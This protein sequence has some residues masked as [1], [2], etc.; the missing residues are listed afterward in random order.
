MSSISAMLLQ[1][2]IDGASVSPEDNLAVCVWSWPSVQHLR[3]AI[4]G[5]SALLSLLLMNSASLAAPT[6]RATSGEFL[7]NSETFAGQERPAVARKRTGEFMVAFEHEPI[8]KP[9]DVNARVF[10]ADGSPL[11][12]Q[13]IVNKIQEGRHEVVPAVGID[14]AGN[15]VVAWQSFGAQ[16][17]GAGSLGVFFRRFSPLGVAL[18]DDIRANSA[19]VMAGPGSDCENNPHFCADVAPTLAV[20]PT[21]GFVIAWSTYVD[22]ANSW[23]VYARRFDAQGNALGPEFRVHTH[24]TNEQRFPA[25]AINAAGEILVAWQS[26]DQD[27]SGCGIFARRFD[28]AN[29]PLGPEFQV[30]AYSIGTQELPGIAMNS[31]GDAVVIWRGAGAG[32]ASGAFARLYSPQGIPRTGDLQ[33]S[34]NPVELEGTRMDVAMDEHGNFVIAWEA[35]HSGTSGIKMRAFGADGT[36]APFE[37]RVNTAPDTHQTMPTV[38]L[39]EQRRLVVAW[40]N[41]GQDGSEWGVYGRLFSLEPDNTPPNPPPHPIVATSYTIT[42]LGLL[43]FQSGF[44]S[45]IN[46][47]GQVV[48]GLDSGTLIEGGSATGTT[49]FVWQAG[50]YTLLP[51]LEGN[52]G[53]PTRGTSALAINDAG[54]IT[55]RS[56]DAAGGKAVV[57]NGG[58][59]TDLGGPHPSHREDVGFD[60]NNAGAI[61]GRAIVPDEYPRPVRWPTGPG[62]L[63]TLGVF[64]GAQ[65]NANAINDSG[66]I[67][68]SFTSG[69]AGESRAFLW[70]NGVESILST[71]GGAF[72]NAAYGIN[73]YGVIVGKSET[74]NGETRAIRWMAGQIEELGTLGGS[75]FS[76]ALA[77][78][79]AGSIVGFFRT[80]SGGFGAFIWQNNVMRDLNALISNLDGWESL[81]PSAINES[82]WIVGTGKR[83]GVSHP[84]LLIPAV[85]RAPVAGDDT[86]TAPEDTPLKIPL[87]TLLANDT[88]PD[89]SALSVTAV[90]NPQNGTVSLTGNEITFTPNLNFNGTASFEY[91]VSDGTFA[92]VGLVTVNVNSVN[93]SPIS[94][95]NNYAVDED[96]LLVGT[97]V[98]GNDKDDHGGAPGENNLP[99]SAE[100]VRPPAYARSFAFRADGTFDYTPELNYDR[101]DS[102]SYRAK[103]ALGALSG[104][105]EVL[106]NVRPINDS[107][108]WNVVILDQPGTYGVLFSFTLPPD[109]FTDPDMGQSIF[110]EASGLPSGIAFDP[111]TRTFSGVPR[112]AGR[113][114]IRVCGTDNGAPPL[115]GEGSFNVVI[116]KAILT[117]SATGVDKVYDGT[118]SA[119]VTLNDNRIS[120]DVFTTSYTGASFN[121]KNVGAAKPVAVS[122]ISIGGPDAG[123]YTVNTTA[124]TTADVSP[125]TLLIGADDKPMIYGDAVPTLTATYQGFVTGETPADLDVPLSLSTAVTELTAVGTY[126]IEAGGASDA[127]YAIVFEDGVLTIEQAQLT[128]TAESATRSYCEPNPVFT[129]MIRGIKNNDNII[130][131]YTNSALPG[132]PAG[133]YPIRPTLQDPGNKLGN[134]DLTLNSGVLMITPALLAVR[135]D[136][137]SKFYYSDN[138]PFSGAIIGLCYGDAIVAVYAS[139]ATKTSPVGTYPIFPLLIDLDGKLFNYVVAA[140]NGTLTVNNDPA[141]VADAGAD[142][143]KVA[144][145]EV[146]FS[147]SFVDPGTAGGA[148]TIRWDFGDGAQDNSGTLT[149]SHIYPKAG[150]YTVTLRVEDDHGGWDDDTLTV[151]VI[152]S[153]SLA[154]DAIDL[155]SPFISESKK[156]EKALQDIQQA[157]NPSRWLDEM[158]LDP[159]TGKQTFNLLQ[160][161]VKELEQVIKDAQKGKVSAAAGQAALEAILKLLQVAQ[162]IS[163]TLY[164]ENENLAAANPANQALVDN[165]LSLALG[166]LNQGKANA[167]AVAYSS[168]MKNFADSWDHTQRAITIAAQP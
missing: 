144:G 129:G 167:A 130:A 114:L 15:Y 111:L 8:G 154:E 37:F 120:G 127:N 92:G 74:A 123:N 163:E 26:L 157:L 98:L 53:S 13:F 38:A 85:N 25:V 82:G 112:A 77:I 110:Y 109:T 16:G 155:L 161:V 89:G 132:S 30:N 61:V 4:A 6:V 142:Q 84:F 62:S 64:A 86:A 45:D 152:S 59:I 12:G 108:Q 80:L 33:V 81:T 131:T 165:E 76:S 28:A 88:D 102:F 83:N 118:A 100:L 136:D 14:E 104:E 66:Q 106:I 115:T 78:N 41:F 168:A 79:N 19:A 160:N 44:A 96:S 31:R 9:V 54:V 146:S 60:I 133:N 150:T 52:A 140:I 148:Y 119:S 43:H 65:G 55:G 22:A 156:I 70:H 138:P 143:D 87:A 121:D 147:G 46:E 159:A 18:S 1:A 94:E 40:H 137:A 57:W 49:A 29:N 34:L 32:G 95:P 23:D 158:H 139:P 99:L 72:E 7:I 63:H 69:A 47:S 134:Y 103:D 166:D 39:D 10:Q 42:D 151:T 124:L 107:P 68:G 117:V 164:L 90:G 116:D 141:P 67:V 91:T 73:D 35:W 17:S 27:G 75:T 153:T 71:L 11:A 48:G 24:V 149:P 125:A 21:S 101:P 128:V 51:P 162:L 5:M 93:D 122:G 113:F 2:P 56:G 145:D 50:Q 58:A 97:S 126:A 135:A 36:G 105:T 20:H 3:R